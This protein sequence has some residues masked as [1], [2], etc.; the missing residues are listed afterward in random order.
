MAATAARE[1]AECAYS[2]RV[3]SPFLNLIEALERVPRPASRARTPFRMEGRSVFSSPVR[4]YP[5]NSR[6][7]HSI[8]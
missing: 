2:H 1:N 3:H 5:E 8:A 6:I 7:L 4:K